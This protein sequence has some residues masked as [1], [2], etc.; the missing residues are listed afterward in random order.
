[1]A[2]IYSLQS[3]D[4]QE[5][6]FCREYDRVSV[7]GGVYPGYSTDAANNQPVDYALNVSGGTLTLTAQGSPS[8]PN[9]GFEVSCVG[10]EDYQM[11]G[12]CV[13]AR[14]SSSGDCTQ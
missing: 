10:M 1:M 11:P 4:W 13:C 5:E 7:E 9:A 3:Y 6:R 2:R 14:D 12:V 8:S